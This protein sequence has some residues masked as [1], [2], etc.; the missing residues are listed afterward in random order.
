MNKFFKLIVSAAFALSSATAGATVVINNLHA[1]ATNISFDVNGTATAIGD[2][3]RHQMAFG[4]VS[5]PSADWISW[6]NGSASSITAG[7][8]TKQAVYAPYDLTGQYGEAVFTVSGS[9]WALNDQLSLHF[10][11]VGTFNLANFDPAGLGFQ[12]GYNN[13]TLAIEQSLNLVVAPQSDVPEPASLALLGLG[14][15]GVAA[16]RRKR[17]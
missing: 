15:A 8:A 12:V 9:N 1:S 14:L 4:H 5:N 11:L 3:Y 6:L 7:G 17:A 16:A 10:N 2:G 13:G